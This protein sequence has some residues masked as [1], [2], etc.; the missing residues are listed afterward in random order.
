MDEIPP[1]SLV[2]LPS[3]RKKSRTNGRFDKGSGGHDPAF[4]DDMVRTRILTFVRAGANFSIAAQSAGIDRRRISDWRKWGKEGREPYATF[5]GEIEEAEAFAEVRLV[6]I[7]SR[8]AETDY[9]AARDLLRVRFRER[10]SDMPVE[11]S[12]D[13]QELA[14]PIETIDQLSEVYAALEEAGQ[15]PQQASG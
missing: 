11:T 5:L 12:L 10:W 4:V 8:H 3:T 15:L 1:L 6:G 7:W 13:A 2:P 14:E 9:R